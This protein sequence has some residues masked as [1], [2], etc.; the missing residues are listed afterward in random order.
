MAA[1]ASTCTVSST[2]LQR[3]RVIWVDEWP[4]HSETT[5]GCTSASRA[6][7]AEGCRRSCSVIRGRKRCL[8]RQYQPLPR[9]PTFSATAALSR[10]P[11][12]STPCPPR[13]LLGVR[14]AVRVHDAT[15]GVRRGREILGG[16]AS[17]QGFCLVSEGRSVLDAHAG[18]A[19]G[20][21]AGRVGPSEPRVML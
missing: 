6:T 10:R 17:D 7:V 11:A 14:R 8:P 3:S 9:L 15:Q 13:G 12:V 20:A 18:A 16:R 21:G 19:H 2:W 5:F 1:A 4:W